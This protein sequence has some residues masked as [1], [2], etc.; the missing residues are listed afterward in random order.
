MKK[1][2]FGALSLAVAMSL[3][4]KVFATVDG[5]EITDVDIAPMFAGVS[6]V[7]LNNL[8]PEIQKQ[9]VDRAIDIRIL[10]NAAKKSGIEKSD[11][12]KKQLEI[13]KDEIA[14][15]AWQARELNNTKVSPKETSEYYEKNKDKFIEPAAMNA[16]HILVK[17]EKTAKD[18]I[19]TLGKLKG[20]ELSKKFSEIAIQKSI[21]PIA[22]QTGGNL[23]W[24]AKGQMVKEFGDAAEKLKNGEFTKTPVKTQFGYHIILKNDS[25]NQK[26]LSLEEVKPYI[27]N[28]VKQIKFQENFE[29]KFKDL[30]AKAKVEYK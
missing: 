11:L 2:L 30:K 25:R 14:L 9:A 12:Y 7:D 21:E 26:Q 22:K 8:P 19:S 27:E 23:G 13:V 29:K 28:V 15:R 16:S 1:I 18:I 24:F 10:I 4:A 3:N 6:G 20:E 5:I 17:D